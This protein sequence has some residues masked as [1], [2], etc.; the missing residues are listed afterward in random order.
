MVVILDH[1][2][3]AF[4]SLRHKHYIPKNNRT[5]H[6]FLASSVILRQY[7]ILLCQVKYNEQSNSNV[8]KY[9]QLAPNKVLM[10]FTLV[11]QRKV[12]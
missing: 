8:K 7:A 11:S 4:P 1:I 2:S 5:V 9:K 12:Y 6:A 10:Q 3:L